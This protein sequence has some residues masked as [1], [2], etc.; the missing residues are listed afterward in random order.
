[1]VVGWKEREVESQGREAHP[2]D[3]TPPSLIRP[4]SICDGHRRAP[5]VSK[6]NKTRSSAGLGGEMRTQSQGAAVTWK[7]LQQISQTRFPKSVQGRKWPH[8]EGES[9]RRA[10]PFYRRVLKALAPRND[11]IH[12]VYTGEGRLGVGDH[13][14]AF[15]KHRC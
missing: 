5:G 12:G 3:S 6:T 11:S 13:L 1:M 14:G 2:T 7:L 15:S 10:T 4:S 8:W 9:L